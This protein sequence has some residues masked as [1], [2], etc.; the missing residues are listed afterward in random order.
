MKLIKNDLYNKYTKQVIGFDTD[1]KKITKEDLVDCF[2][3]HCVNLRVLDE[4]VN[5]I[6]E[7]IQKDN[8]KED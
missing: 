7:L 6:Y 8:K 1:F 2:K 4:V 5:Y 3:F